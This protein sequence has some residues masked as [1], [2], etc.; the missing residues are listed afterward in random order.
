MQIKTIIKRVEN[1]KDFDLSVNEALKQGWILK[2]RE[3]RWADQPNTHQ[4]YMRNMLYAELVKGDEPEELE[5]KVK[6]FNENQPRLEKITVGD[7]IDLSV[8]VGVH[9]SSKNDVTM[10]PLGIGMI[11]PEGY[12]AHILPR[13]STAKQYGIVM[14]NSMGIVDNS[15]SGN[16]DEWKFPAIAIND[17]H[18]TFIPTG[19]RIAQF[20]IV[21]NQPPIRFTTVE[22]L[23]DV[24]RGGFGSTG[25]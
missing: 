23:N 16:E 4:V 11:L 10:I 25:H 2:K 6:Y 12:E 13:S 24:S 20:R 3:I 18:S 15:Y 22:K 14:A 17:E 21:K 7:W 8:R 1:V 5:I 19:A 9:I